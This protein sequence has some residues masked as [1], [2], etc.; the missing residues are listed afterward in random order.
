VE[1]PCLVDHNG[2]QPVRIGALPPHL[3]ALMQTN[4]N[5]QTLTVEAALTGKREH[6]YHAAMLDPHTAAELNLDQIFALVDALL[7]AHQQWL[8]K[9]WF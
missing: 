8:P 1:I 3:A 2:V 5:V 6:V 7:T 9:G 4:I